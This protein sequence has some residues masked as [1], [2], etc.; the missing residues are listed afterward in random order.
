MQHVVDQGVNFGKW[1]D[2]TSKLMYHDV[3]ELALDGVDVTGRVA[4]Y[5]GANG[6][7]KQWIPQALSVDY[8][9]TKNPDIC[10]DIKTHCGEYDMI[11]MRYVLHYMDDDTVIGLLHNI[12]SYHAGRLLI[13]QFVNEDLVSKY[14]NSIGEVKWFRD[15]ADLRA[16][17]ER[18]WTIDKRRSTDYRVDAEFYRNRLQH[19]NPS[20]HDERIVIYELTRR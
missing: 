19:P 14:S 7:L 4:D 12:A 20:S 5:G 17:L 9:L 3:M 15:E 11:V 18:A 13:I 10:D 16:L 8:D 1:G 6:M 2:P